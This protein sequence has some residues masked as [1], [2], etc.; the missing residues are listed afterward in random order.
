MVCS[1]ATCCVTAGKALCGAPNHKT[2]ARSDET[3]RQ[4]S[5]LSQV[6]VSMRLE[7]AVYHLE[8]YTQDEVVLEWPLVTQ[9]DQIKCLVPLLSY[10]QADVRVDEENLLQHSP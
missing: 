2:E 5:Y 4:P 8:R 9:S 3:Q 6:P 10:S 1:H 7:L